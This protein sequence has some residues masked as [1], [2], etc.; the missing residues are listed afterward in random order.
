MALIVTRANGEGTGETLGVARAIADPDNE[1][2]EFA[3]AARSDMKG[4]GLGSL[5]LS[6]IIDYVKQRGTRWLVGEA[7]RENA[8]MIALARNSGFELTK[9]DDPTVVGFRMRLCDT[10]A[11][12]RAD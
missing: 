7:L 10:P 4:K 11:Q 5:L 8:G 1:T 9:T 3:V 12:P 2:A 6:R